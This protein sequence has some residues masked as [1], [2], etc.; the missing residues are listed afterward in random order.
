[1][2]A[3]LTLNLVGAKWMGDLHLRR[4]NYA[5]ENLK[6]WEEECSAALG[7]VDPWPY[8]KGIDRLGRTLRWT[9]TWLPLMAGILFLVALVTA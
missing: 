5:A 7:R 9:K 6:R 8:T 4:I 3:S 1:L 2:I